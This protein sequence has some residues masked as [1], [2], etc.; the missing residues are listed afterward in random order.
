MVVVDDDRGE[1]DD[2]DDLMENRAR[3]SADLSPSLS[4]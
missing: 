2:R 1:I 3:A 4:G